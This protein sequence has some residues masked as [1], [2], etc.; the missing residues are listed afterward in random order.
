MRRVT[1]HQVA[2]VCPLQWD[3][4]SSGARGMIWGISSG[5]QSAGNPVC[6]YPYCYDKAVFA[7]S[8][9]KGLFGH[10]AALVQS[11]RTPQLLCLT[12]SGYTLGEDKP[13]QRLVRAN[14]LC[15]VRVIPWAGSRNKLSP[16]SK[17]KTRRR[18]SAPTVY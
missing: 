3:S 2:E 5:E 16:A 18:D 12:H 15:N 11:I 10:V 6:S 13:S 7:W 8:S 1:L 14:A 4:Q 17:S 9:F